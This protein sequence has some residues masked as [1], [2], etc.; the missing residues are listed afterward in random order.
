MAKPI[1]IYLIRTHAGV[2][3]TKNNS[4]LDVV[5]QMHKSFIHIIVPAYSELDSA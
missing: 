5:Y 2:F 4:R 1:F 3:K